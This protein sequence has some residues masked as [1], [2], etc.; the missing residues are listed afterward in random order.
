MHNSGYSS[1]IPPSVK[2]MQVDL[3][4]MLSIYSLVVCFWPNSDQYVFGF[5][6]QSKADNKDLR[7][8]ELERQV[9]SLIAERDAV[10]KR[11]KNLS[12]DYD[13]QS[14]RI[15]HYTFLVFYIFFVKL[16]KWIGHINGRW[17]K[18]T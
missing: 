5:A 15:T 10:L 12:E 1:P 9:A 4:S 13:K 18:Q 8:E 7:I 11:F 17:F 14:V 16:Q 2:V 6:F 3:N